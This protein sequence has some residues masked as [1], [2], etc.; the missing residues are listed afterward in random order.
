ME[1]QCSNCQ[2]PKSLEEFSK[3]NRARDGKQ[4]WCKTCM[5]EAVKKHKQKKKRQNVRKTG[6]HYKTSLPE[7]VWKAC[8]TFLAVLHIYSEK[9]Y[10]VGVKPDIA[11]FMSAYAGYRGCGLKKYDEEGSVCKKNSKRL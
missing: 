1:K 4:G 9:T 2:T 8:F 7:G 6:V 10:R 11:R 3:A 5:Q